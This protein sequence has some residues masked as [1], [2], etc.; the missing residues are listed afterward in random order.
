VLRYIHPQTLVFVVFIVCAASSC[1]TTD[2][3][4]RPLTYSLTAKQNYEKGLMELKAENYTDAVRHFTYVKQKYPFSKY[5]A[6]AELALADTQYERTSYVAAVD[7]FKMFQRLHP[8]HEKVED[9]YV[10]FRVCQCYV[11]DMP[12]DWAILPP[13]SEKDQSPVREAFRELTDFLERFPDSKYTKEAKKLRKNVVSR[14]IDHEVYVARFYSNQ[15]HPKG[16]ILRLEAAIRNYPDSGR[17]AELLFV[18]GQTH[19]QTG[20]TASAKKAF[21]RVKNEYGTAAQT[22]RAELYLEFIKQR[23]GDNPKDKVIDG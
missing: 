17:E 5:A 13:A 9:G 7:A 16:A 11:K 3:S 15:G 22:S 18:L 10:A 23:Y 21:E 2:E 19:L 14:L 4:G 12:D 20:K 1:A 6:L 8:T